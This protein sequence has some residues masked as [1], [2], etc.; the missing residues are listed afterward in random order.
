MATLF[1]LSGRGKLGAVE[2]T[3][4]YMEAHGIPG[5]LLHPAAA[6]EIT[7][8]LLLLTGLYTSQVSVLL[9]GWCLLTAFIFHTKFDDQNEI[10]HLLKNLAIA[11]GFLVLAD[12]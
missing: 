10:V 6:F 11:G 9:A 3:R 2:P 1:L 12:L 4:K 5:R 8:G 7:S